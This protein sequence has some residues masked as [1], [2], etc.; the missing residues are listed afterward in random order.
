[1]PDQNRP[2]CPITGRPLPDGHTI[3]PSLAG[4][5]HDAANR[6]AA[7][8]PETFKHTPAAHTSGAR[9]QPTSRPPANLTRL[10]TLQTLT[11]RLYETTR[12]QIQE[13]THKEPPA[14]WPAITRALHDNARR[15]TQT[16]NAPTTHPQIT[17]L[18][19]QIE[20]TLKPAPAPYRISMCTTCGETMPTNTTNTTHT[21]PLC[22]S[23]FNINQGRELLL[24]TA[25][26]HALLTAEQAA[27]ILTEL[28]YKTT[29]AQ[30]RQ[31]KHRGKLQPAR[32][33]PTR[34]IASHI[35]QLAKLD[36]RH[37]LIDMLDA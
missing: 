34:Y 25:Y 24:D 36:K 21:C 4:E 18:L 29:P 1:M 31:W 27:L 2:T 7:V 8:I 16:P 35:A 17:R 10:Q 3:H 22:G 33:N 19:N 6:I 5:I 9:T 12:Q 11:R 13:A 30:I 28:G 26:N 32:L 23:A 20:H 14:T 15:I 37:T